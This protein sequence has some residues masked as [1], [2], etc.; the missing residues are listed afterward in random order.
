MKMGGTAIHF[1]QGGINSLLGSFW[2]Y[3]AGGVVLLVL[4]V[5]FLLLLK[6][7]KTGSKKSP[8]STTRTIQTSKPNEMIQSIIETL[9]RSNG[10]S[11]TLLLAACRLGDLPV[12][13]PLNLAIHLSGKGKCLLID[14]DSKRDALA[15]VFDIDSSMVGT[16]LRMLP[17][18]TSFENLSIW[19][20]RYFDLLKQ[21]N[22]GTLLNAANKKYDHTL[23]YAPYLT[24]LADRKQIASCSKQAIVFC[25]QEEN[26]TQARLHRL[27]EMYNCKILRKV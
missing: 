17:V 26:E 25:Q 2:P 4:L 20:A 19:P 21:M 5:I 8:K 14:L 9:P 11:Q 1:L 18:Q 24:V 23:L 15:R 7:K 3:L 16:R 12:T 27:L 13:I 6:R 10:Q 22:L